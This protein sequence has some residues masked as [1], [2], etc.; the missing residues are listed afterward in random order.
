VDWLLV[1]ACFEQD[2]LFDRM[3]MDGK[4]TLALMAELA[5]EIAAF[6]GRAPRR[7]E[8]GGRKDIALVVKSNAE[9]VAEYDPG[10]LAPGDA[11]RLTAESRAALD[12]LS[13]H[14][15]AGQAM[16][17]VRR[18][19]GDLHLRNFVLMDDR[20]PLFNAIEFSEHLACIDV[21]YDVAFL[22]MD[23]VHRS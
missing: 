8:H 5:D 3:A 9:A 4:L 13:P 15:E 6:H 21:L 16:G 17:R 10:I 18:C 20:P 7:P 23:L 11:S 1:M 22:I 2:T 12:R 19:H 14:L